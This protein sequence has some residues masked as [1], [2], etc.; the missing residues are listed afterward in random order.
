MAINGPYRITKDMVG[1]DYKMKLPYIYDVYT[2]N[3][4]FIQTSKDLEALGV[5]NN[6]FFLKLYD[7]E[8]L[9]VDPYSDAL[10]QEQIKRIIIECVRNP[11]Y[12]LRE[13]ARI[14][15]Q[16]GTLGPGGGDPFILHR[17]N[18]AATYCFLHNINHYMVI[19]RQC[20]KTQSEIAI[21]AW[22]YLFGTTNSE[23]AFINKT[24]KDANDNL[25]RLKQQKDLLPL[26]LQQ[27]FKL[28]NG[29]LKANQGKDN[30][31]TIENALNMNRIVTKPSAKTVEAA[32]NIG[33][34]NTSP[35]QF[36]DEV[37]FTTHIGYILKAAGP[38]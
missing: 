28:V 31:Q 25:T 34:G 2:K 32:E 7:K 22:V 13:L 30:V 27:K 35:I 24:Q 21:L 26:Y 16:G 11:W 19:P 3:L 10:T 5:K 29:E 18:L 4:S 23:I 6:K 8:L 17:A 36:Y 9:G 38:A 33:R 37:E 12:Y 20:G 14:P 1:Y 15:A